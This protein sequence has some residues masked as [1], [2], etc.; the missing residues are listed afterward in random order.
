MDLSS[1]QLVGVSYNVFVFAY[2]FKEMV[3]KHS[4]IRKGC[5]TM[6]GV[7]RPLP[8]ELSLGEMGYGRGDVALR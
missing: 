1:V 7:S 5:L 3:P 4:F 6:N 2:E 8:S